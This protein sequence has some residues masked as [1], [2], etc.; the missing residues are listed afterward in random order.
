L[1]EK[2]QE[3]IWN[4]LKNYKQCWIRESIFG[5]LTNWL[6]DRIKTILIFI[7]INNF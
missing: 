4:N 7:A 2:K 1:G 5:I 3:K 6:G